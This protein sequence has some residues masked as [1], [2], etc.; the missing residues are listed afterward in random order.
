MN[1]VNISQQQFEKSTS[2]FIH[3]HRINFTKNSHIFCYVHLEIHFKLCEVSTPEI[4]FRKKRVNR[5]YTPP[6]FYICSKN[7]EIFRSNVGQPKLRTSNLTK[8]NIRHTVVKP[9][10]HICKQS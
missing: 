2:K 8:G 10:S 4:I 6:V 5:T 7:Y 9:N 1:I 3:L